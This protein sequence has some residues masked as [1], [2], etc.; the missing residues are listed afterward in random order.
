MPSARPSFAR[1]LAPLMLKGLAALLAVCL[2]AL[3]ALLL[4]L[5]T[6][7]ALRH[8]EDRLTTAFAAQ[9]FAL[10]V[11][12]SAGPLPGRLHLTGIAL[13]DA[14]GPLLTADSLVFTVDLPSLLAA[15]IEVP[16]LRLEAPELF[17]LPTLPPDDEPQAASGS[18]PALPVDIV[19]GSLAINNGVLHAA[20]LRPD[21]ASQNQAQK[22]KP[23]A[24]AATAQ[25]F[26]VQ[27][28]A[29]AALRG[30]NLSADLQGGLLDAK[31]QGLTLRAQLASSL[32][33]L[34]HD[35]PAHAGTKAHAEKDTLTLQL[36]AREEHDGPAALL[37][38]QN[39][40]PAFLLSLEG[41][42]PVTDWSGSLRLDLDHP[43]N[44]QPNEAP[45]SLLQASLSLDLRCKTGSFF[46]DLITQPAF[47]LD[48]AAR[49]A[50]GRHSP[51]AYPPVLGESSQAKA[52]ITASGREYTAT[53]A[54]ASPALQL[55]LETC[56]LAPYNQANAAPEP[57]RT[58]GGTVLTTGLGLQAALTLTASDPAALAA[59]AAENGLPPETPLRSLS[60]R[61]DINGLLTDAFSGLA[62]RGAIRLEA[63]ADGFDADYALT[64]AL[65]DAELMLRQADLRGLGLVASASA[66]AGRADR[67]VQ[68]TA[69]LTADDHAPWQQL[70]A[71]LAGFGEEQ[72]RAPPD[73]KPFGG[74][75][76]LETSLDFS[77][78]A[79]AG[80][81]F[82]DPAR[83]AAGTLLFTARDMR[84]PLAALTEALGPSIAAEATLSGGGG[85]PYAV[86]LERLQAGVLSAEGSATLTA[87]KTGAPDS[88]AATLESRFQAEISDLAPLAGI[89]AGISGPLRAVVT[90]DGSLRALRLDLAL[91]SPSL[92]LPTGPL[93]E[94]ALRVEGETSMEHDV[95]A[96]KGRLKATIGESP[97]G[98][99]SLVSRWEAALPA[100]GAQDG[101]GVRVWDVLLQGAGLQLTADLSASAS[102]P[103]SPFRLKGTARAEISN[104]GKLAALAGTSLSG[105]PAAL[106]CAFEHKADKQS[107]AL[108]LSLPEL[109]VQEPGEQP[110]LL[111]KD[112]SA[113]MRAD[114]LFGA[115]GIDLSLRAGKGKAAFLRWTDGAFTVKGTGGTGK[116]DLALRRER[117]GRAGPQGDADRLSMRG[118]YDL[119]RQEV[120]LT[121][122]A[123]R[124]PASN[125]GLR[126]Q[127]PLRFG[128]AQGLD[129]KDLDLAFQ[130]AG[131][132]T[133][134]ATLGPDLV[135]TRADLEG[136]PFAFFRLFTSSPLPDGTMTA[137]AN[138]ESSAGGLTGT[139]SLNSRISATRPASGISKTASTEEAPLF[140]LTLDGRFSGP[141]G[142]NAPHWLQA[143]GSFGSVP[144]AAGAGAGNA[145]R[146]G[147]VTLRLPL[148]AAGGSLPLPDPAAP[149]EASLYWQGPIATLW[150][151]LP[152]PD[153]YFSGQTLL[154]AR[155]G[156]TLAAPKPAI[157][158]YIAGGRFEDV[159]NGLL[160]NGISLEAKSTNEKGLHALLAANDGGSGNLAVE[161][162][163]TGIEGAG[164]PTLAL[165][166]QLDSF[167]P[168]HRDDLKLSLSGIFSVNGPVDEPDVTADILVDHGELVLSSSL[169][170]S[171]S[172]LDVENKKSRDGEEA[173]RSDTTG[174]A[175]AK[176]PALDLHI[177]LPQQFFIHGMGLDSEWEGDLRISGRAAEPSLTG[178]LR[179]IRGYL[180]ILSRT[181][182]FTGGDISFAGGMDVNPL[183]NLELSHEGPDITGIIRVGGTAK[184][185]KLTVDS[186]PPLPRDEVLAH[187]LFGKPVSELSRF[188]A[189]Q[190]A[191]SI[192]EL[193]G[194]GGS[195]LDVMGG[196]R[197]KT[198]LDMLRLGGTETGSRRDTSGQSGEGN[199]V[200]K[201]T[202]SQAP[203]ASAALPSLE[204]GKYINDSIYVGVEQGATGDSTAVRV[205]VE[206]FP[207]VMLEG[208][209]SA[210]SSEV[211]FGWKMDY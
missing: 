150:Q 2:V 199:I 66:R 127:R 32:A 139:I 153:R 48:L 178:A 174:T 11:Q 170:G 138:I 205:E 196:L 58:A 105:A 92:T 206:L 65:D 136:L 165:R 145:H 203:A 96:G 49:L 91:S 198:G 90:T 9:G 122:F 17:R 14:D 108:S 87:A 22:A 21:A 43:E 45:G 20:A 53:L 62:A 100:A 125:T 74:A 73:A 10:S 64:A 8:L 4:W 144:A 24:P 134:D 166:G 183:I 98:P 56:R 148:R 123:L 57:W 112:L 33:R 80:D 77:G 137:A 175:T 190:L 55:S 88:A 68:A 40:L 103:P 110:A 89:D 181:F 156:G 15:R 107:A 44:L 120:L 209:S 37:F 140:G 39:E 75:L 195:S 185:P 130:P 204:A 118:E 168:L 46:R 184:K 132:L 111:L 187:V 3:G 1:R 197:K 182:A 115:P 121:A 34:L 52:H 152:L 193:T 117:R 142:P 12:E 5:R 133:A 71:N 23:E 128:F 67:A 201:P 82:G 102:A 114:D 143:E 60:I 147:T 157:S 207:K 109:R 194:T 36:A 30:N 27:L 50:P 171:V 164:V 188:E 141:G 83:Q 93:R 158:A 76:R 208:K 70:L 69:T 113:A 78:Y 106:E 94:L 162:S 18:F 177:A 173:D 146:E 202:Q 167:R 189:I 180:D 51:A 163:L 84:W 116:L 131:R 79:A 25:R 41:S 28:S 154:D 192:R 161:A 81:L 7:A 191:N 169:G 135:R 26:S 211:G 85:K 38:G 35:E 129:V 97:G 72:R 159:I 61:S 16:E 124:D 19:L 6:P 155:V 160:I 210:S 186:K 59:L 119:K 176:G 29:S 172:T 99:L 31:G 200:G 101:P 42:G 126:L 104:W 95:T 151:V 13:A 149:L 47:T 179:P 63:G 54:A 86:R